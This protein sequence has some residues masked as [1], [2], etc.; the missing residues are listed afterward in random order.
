MTEYAQ[1]QL[2]S[3]LIQTHHSPPYIYVHRPVM[4]ENTTGVVAM[5]QNKVLSLWLVI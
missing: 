3:S 1:A 4:K 5:W 2:Q